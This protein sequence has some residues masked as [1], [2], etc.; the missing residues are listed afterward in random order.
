MIQ[1]ILVALLG[2]C[3]TYACICVRDG[4]MEVSVVFAILSFVLY[5]LLMNT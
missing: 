1:W 4:K 3:V 2:G 5:V